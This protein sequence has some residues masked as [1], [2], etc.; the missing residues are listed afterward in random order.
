MMFV[1]GTA[2]PVEVMSGPLL[3]IGKSLPLYHAALA[4]QDAWNGLGVNALQLGIVTAVA[5]GGLALTSWLFRW[6]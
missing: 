4:L 5:A 1:S 3:G 2:P 6:D